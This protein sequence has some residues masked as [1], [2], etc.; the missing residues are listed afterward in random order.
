MLKMKFERKVIE[1]IFSSARPGRDA[2]AILRLKSEFS[3]NFIVDSDI[4]KISSPESLSQE[5][6][7]LS[8]QNRNLK[9]KLIYRLF[10]LFVHSRVN[11]F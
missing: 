1:W 10:F 4:F 3:I 11:K 2:Q 6:L 9:T 7:N 8:C 5:G